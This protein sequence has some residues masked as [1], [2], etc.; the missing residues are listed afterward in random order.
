MAQSS[1]AESAVTADFSELSQPL[2][3]E[4]DGLSPPTIEY[5]RQQWLAWSSQ[6]NIPS[7]VKDFSSA[8]MSCP[9]WGAEERG[10]GTLTAGETNQNYGATTWSSLPNPWPTYHQQYQPPPPAEDRSSTHWSTPCSYP[11][12][13]P[14]SQTPLEMHATLGPEMGA[15]LLPSMENVQPRASSSTIQQQLRKARTG[16]AGKLALT[17]SAAHKVDDATLKSDNGQQDEP[18][19]GTP[20]PGKKKSYRVRNRAAAKRCREKTKQYELDLAAKEQDIAQERIYLDACVTALRNEVLD[21][22]SQILQHSDCDCE[23][24]QGYIARAASGV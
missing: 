18:L 10:H 4:L 13:N 6:I 22:K 9:Q 8:A 19:H 24:I 12:S 3:P 1:H 14:A 7:H 15:D 5:S 16:S 11:A 23:I 21:L 17:S 2:Y 20:S